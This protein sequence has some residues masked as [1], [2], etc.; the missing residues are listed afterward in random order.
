MTSE[1][2]AKSRRSPL[3][4]TFPDLVSLDLF[5]TTVRLGSISAAAS[6]HNMSQPSVS[7]RIRALETRL[8]LQ[9]L[10]RSA[11]GSEP[12]SD[13]AV[14]AEWTEALLTSADELASAVEALRNREPEALRIAASYTV[15]EF[16]LPGWV[17]SWRIRHAGVG[18][19][20]SVMNST[21]VI[22]SV[23]DGSTQVGF[24]ESR[25]RTQGLRSREVGGDELVVVVAP[26]HP[27]AHRRGALTA[28][29]LSRTPFV[30]REPGSGTREAFT[31]AL[32]DAGCDEPAVVAEL[33]STAAVREAVAAGLGPAALSELAVQA[34]LTAGRLVNVKVSG[35][36]LTRRFRAVW[37]GTGE[38]P[39]PIRELVAVARSGE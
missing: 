28:A 31:A 30:M 16:L 35:V 1:G 23:I 3:P 15:A 6:E 11:S 12:T 39:S 24:I 26:D 2:P 29:Q 25:G 20:L 33:G 38:P 32:V 10:T 13:G 27:W 17:T 19:E 37:N 34:E 9:L 5:A 18:I 7:T 36:D 4:P 8:G 21:A 14:V 22:N